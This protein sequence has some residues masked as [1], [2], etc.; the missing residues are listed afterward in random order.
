MK[1]WTAPEI[2]PRLPAV[3][4]V[5]CSTASAWTRSRSL[6]SKGAAL[7]AADGIG[8]TIFDVPGG[9]LVVGAVALPAATLEGYI[10]RDSPK[11]LGC[12]RPD[13]AG[14][15]TFPFRGET[16]AAGLYPVLRGNTQAGARSTGRSR[17][18]SCC[19]RP[20]T[21]PRSGTMML[22]LRRN[23]RYAAPMLPRQQ[24]QP[25]GHKRV[26]YTIKRNGLRK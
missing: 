20:A 5:P 23:T 22:P 11:P 6:N 10:Q 12:G 3:T 21:P 8:P 7:P 2:P 24:H 14:I 9:I 13:R 18:L 16:L 26:N 17:L 25:Q 4:A 15:L 19:P 1:A